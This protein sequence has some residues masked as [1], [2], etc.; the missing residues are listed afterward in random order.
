M[1]FNSN[2][3]LDFCKI[4]LLLYSSNF[5]LYFELETKSFK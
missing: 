5:Y 3:A 2:I 4:V 1:E